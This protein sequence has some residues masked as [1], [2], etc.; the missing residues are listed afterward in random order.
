MKLRLLAAAA[1][2]ALSLGPTGAQVP[3]DRL[4]R[5]PADARRFVIVSGAGEHGRASLWRGADGTLNARELILLRGFVFEWDQAVHI[6]AGGVPD[7]VVVRGVDPSGDVAETFE[8]SG[9]AGRWTSRNDEG[10][11]PFDGRSYYVTANGPFIA[12]AVL[13][14]ALYRAPGHRLGSA[15]RRRGAADAAHRRQ[16]RRG[17]A[18]TDDHRLCDRRPAARSAAGL[19]ERRRQ[20]FRLRFFSFALCRKAIPARAPSSS[21]RRRRRWRS[22]ARRSPAASARCPRRPSPSPTCGC[23]TPMPAASSTARRWSP[24]AA[25]SP[26]SAPTASM[27][28]PASARIIDGS[29]KTL[30]PGIWDAHMHV[31]SDNQGVM[32]LSMGD[33]LGARSGRRDRA[34]RPAPGPGRARRAAVPDRLFLGADR[35]R[36]AAPGAG[37]GQRRFRR[38]GGRRRA[39]GR[40]SK[41][42]PASNSTPRCGANGCIPAIAEARRLGPP[43]PRPHPGDDAPLRRRRRRL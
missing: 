34:D 33:D 24:K 21:G 10:G 32:L 37:R 43:R 4:M 5:P 6:G 1:V 41:A 19:A 3:A 18:A 27:T 14:E 16:R 13:A 38:G 2:A 40:A 42:I 11:G 28:L 25:G 22:A 31:G 23:S 15:A 20:L 39:P 26:P 30:L 7:R 9:D 36:R 8:A 35:R 29:G 17:R 12:N